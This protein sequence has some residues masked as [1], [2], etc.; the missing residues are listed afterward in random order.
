MKVIGLSD[1]E[2]QCL[3][4]DIEVNREYFENAIEENPDNCEY[5]K[6][7]L[8]LQERFKSLLESKGK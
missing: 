2:L 8:N 1:Y 3:I 5:E 7:M 6:T 4:S